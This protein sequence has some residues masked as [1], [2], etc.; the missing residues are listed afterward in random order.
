[1]TRNLKRW[2]LV[3]LLTFGPQAFAAV[4]ED[5]RL[6]MDI[7]EGFQGPLRGVPGP[8]ALLIGYTKPYPSAQ[9]GT[10]LQISRF[11]LGASAKPLPHA[12]RGAAA[13][14]YLAQL[15]QGV[16]RKRTKFSSSPP[17]RLTLDGFAAASTEWQGDAEGHAMTGVMYCVVVGDAMVSLHT[18]DFDDAPAGNRVEVLQAFDGIR[19]KPAGASSD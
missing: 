5:D 12:E 1:M 18:Q 7:P 11:E 9:R 10:L 8:G 19:F 14:K 4:Y 3:A 17:R 2:L 6:I 15:I 13:E 16:E